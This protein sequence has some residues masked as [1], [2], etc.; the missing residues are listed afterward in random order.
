MPFTCF[1]YLHVV[2]RMCEDFLGVDHP[3][4]RVCRWNLKQARSWSE[5]GPPLGVTR[6][7]N[8]HW[9]GGMYYMIRQAHLEDE[10]EKWNDLFESIGWRPNEADNG[11]PE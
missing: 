3:L 4:S 2:E 6:M 1:R 5:T 10:V 7:E 8:D 9:D 11:D